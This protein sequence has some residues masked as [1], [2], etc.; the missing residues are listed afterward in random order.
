MAIQGDYFW[1]EEAVFL[2]QNIGYEINLVK[3][4]AIK[5]ISSEF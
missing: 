3:S 2:G 5:P 1:K 4:G